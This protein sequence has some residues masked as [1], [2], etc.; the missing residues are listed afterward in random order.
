MTLVQCYVSHNASSTFAVHNNQTLDSF[1]R[2]NS[3]QRIFNFRLQRWTNTDK[4]DKNFQSQSH[5]SI[6]W[7]TGDQQLP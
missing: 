4:S 7:R 3:F 6:N 1:V 2:L 5:V